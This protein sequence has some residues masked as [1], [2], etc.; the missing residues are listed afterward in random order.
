MLNGWYLLAL[1]IQVVIILSVYKA[2]DSNLP[3]IKQ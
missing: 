3:D 2:R 1:L